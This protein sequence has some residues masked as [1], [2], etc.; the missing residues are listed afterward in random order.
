MGR[1]EHSRK[2][3]SASLVTR[4]A[5]SLVIPLKLLVS[6]HASSRIRDFLES[7]ACRCLKGPRSDR[8]TRRYAEMSTDIP[9]QQECARLTSSARVL[10]LQ[11]PKRYASCDRPQRP[12]SSVFSD[13][14]GM[15]FP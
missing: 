13:S 10:S 15:E 2:P 3:A 9:Y 4:L 1:I 12:P 6:A 7:A 5:A 8:R 11:T 14:T